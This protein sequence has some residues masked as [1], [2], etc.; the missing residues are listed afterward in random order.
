MP[1]TQNKEK[2][3]KYYTL[4]Q[5]QEKLHCVQPFHRIVFRNE[6]IYPCYVGFN[7]DLKLGSIRDTKIYDAWHSPKMNEIREI[8]KKGEYYKNKTCKDCVDLIY[9]V[10]Y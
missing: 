10:N 1:P 5:Y 4:D 3:K 8:H 6:Y 7:K 2:Y 9:P